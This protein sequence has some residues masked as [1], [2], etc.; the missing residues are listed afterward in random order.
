MC[1]FANAVIHSVHQCQQEKTEGQQ[2][3]FRLPPC[4]CWAGGGVVFR[5]HSMDQPSP[6]VTEVAPAPVALPR[7]KACSSWHNSSF[8]H[9][10]PD[11]VVP[12]WQGTLRTALVNI[13]MKSDA[14]LWHPLEHQEQSCW[15]PPCDRSAWLWQDSQQG[16]QLGRTEQTCQRHARDLLRHNP[17]GPDL[18]LPMHWKHPGECQE[19]H[20]ALLKWG[21]VV[22]RSQGHPE[23]LWSCH[24]W[25]A[26][27]MYS[28]CV[29]LTARE[30]CYTFHRERSSYMQIFLCRHV[31]EKDS[32]AG[33]APTQT[34]T[35]PVCFGFTVSRL[36]SVLPQA[37]GK[38]G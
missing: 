7:H 22:R 34:G 26:H 24:E 20:H 25:Q 1:I 32:T 27:T 30:R 28:G 37:K 14:Q 6:L 31:M 17:A 4:P 16:M 5:T 38:Q 35:I 15:P 12:L 9:N 8:P 33:L 3:R 21:S 19:S 36:I 23:Q 13:K 10:L 11:Q 18:V 29:S 2:Q